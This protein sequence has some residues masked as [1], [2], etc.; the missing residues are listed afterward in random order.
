MTD[1]AM[2]LVRLDD[3]DLTI[4]DGADD[5]RGHTVLDRSGD[6]TGKV[7][8][9]LIDRGLRKVR[10]LEVASGGFLG[11]GKRKVLVPV[12]AV[13]RVDDEHVHLSSDRDHVAS[14][15][16]YDPELTTDDDP[17]RPYGEDVYGYYGL[18]PHW[19]AGYIYPGYPF[20]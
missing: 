6:E 13:T 2:T 9:L 12:G 5:V 15:P 7:E 11:L 17:G 16:G 18:M 3:T 10:F 8:G 19:S 14:G 1:Q 20:R 4:A